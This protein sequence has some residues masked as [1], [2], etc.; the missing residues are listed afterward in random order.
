MCLTVEVIPDVFD[1]RPGLFLEH[2]D[3]VRSQLLLVLVLSP[4]EVE[5]Y[6]T[7]MVL[8]NIVQV[9]LEGHGCEWLGA[10]D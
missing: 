7:L 8:D 4:N 3:Q 2:L 9:P 5:H 6:Y 1:I 10:L